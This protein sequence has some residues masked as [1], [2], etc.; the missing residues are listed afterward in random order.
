MELHLSRVDYSVMGVAN[1]NCLKLLPPSTPKEQ[2]KV[3]LRLFYE[4]QFSEP[5]KL[6]I[7]DFQVA[8]ADSDGT[9]QVFSV[10][11]DDIQLHFKTLPGPP[12]T[13]VK[14]AGA[15]GQ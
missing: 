8:I 10:K 14:I 3:I 11:K 4:L 9:L 6:K 7:S 2:Q 1:K 12:I 5:E 15:T 13:S